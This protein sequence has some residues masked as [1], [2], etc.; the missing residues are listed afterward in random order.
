MGLQAEDLLG[1]SPED[2]WDAQAAARARGLFEAALAGEPADVVSRWPD[3]EG[4]CYRSCVFA[5]PGDGGDRLLGG[6]VFDV[7]EQQSAQ[8]ELERH[9]GR[10][11]KSLEGAVQAMSSIVER[12]DPYTAGHERRVAELA[13]AIARHL[14]VSGEDLEGLR[15]AAGIHDIG[16]ISVPAEILSKPGRLTEVEFAIIKAHSE[17]GHD[18]LRTIAFEQPV[19]EIVLQHHERLDGSG[20]P[21][22][23]SGEGIL[24]EARI[25]AVA[26]VYEAMTSHRPYRPGLPREAAVAELRDGAG[27]RYDQEVVAACL[28]VLDEGF[29]FTAA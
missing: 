17:T 5:M 13:E 8:Q 9:A 24:R 16:K 20:Y 21:Q 15:L 7:T 26:D 10:L 18:V 14:G 6:L 29:V 25:I 3:D 23:L 28:H 12:R 2:L 22:G 19:A 4:Q 27:T 1:K 11:H